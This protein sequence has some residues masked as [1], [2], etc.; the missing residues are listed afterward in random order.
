MGKTNKKA[1]A[2]RGDSKN[3]VNKKWTK[4]KKLAASVI[5]LSVVGTL[6]FAAIML[7]SYLTGVRPIKST[8]EEARVVGTCAGY[9]VRYEELRYVTEMNKRELDKKYGEYSSL[10]DKTRESYN[11]ELS[12]MSRTI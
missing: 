4:K 1:L 7:V 9:E 5:A 10:D 12:E 2:V 3:K 8:D 11:E 6:I